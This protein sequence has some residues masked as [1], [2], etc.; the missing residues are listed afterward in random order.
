MRGRLGLDL[1]DLD[2]GSTFDDLD[3]DIATLLR[4]GD[5]D[6][7]AGRDS[8]LGLQDRRKDLAAVEADGDDTNGVGN[9]LDGGDGGV[10]RLLNVGSLVLLDERGLEGSTAGLQLRWVDG[11]GAGGGRL[12]D[13]RRGEDTGEVVGDAGRV[14]GATAHDDL[15]NVEHVEAG[16][17]DGTLDQAVE[18]LKDLARNHLVADAVNGGRVVEAF[19]KTLDG[20]LGIGAETESLLG[21]LGLEAELGEGA[22]ILAGVGGVLLHELLGE[23][24]H[25]SVVQVDTGKV[26]VVDSGENGVHSTA[27]GNDGDIGA[28]ATQVSDNNELVSDDGLLAGIVGE[29]GGNGVRDELEDF[30]ASSA[31]GGSEGLTLLVSEVGRHGDDGRG[32]LLA[33]VV[34]GRGGEAAEEAS[35]R[36]GDGDGRGLNLGRGGGCR[37]TRARLSLG[38]GVLLLVLDGE[39]DLAINILGVGGSMAVRGVDRLEAILIFGLA[40]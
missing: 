27:R 32:D 24:V 31:G 22:R 3:Q 6:G 12:D 33:E 14:R 15:V 25:E 23:V 10:R 40:G 9:V 38:G 37:G 8:R 2:V 36:L 34:G 16:L 4:G 18:A 11:S 17:L 29:N 26:V 28:S 30:K 13:G 20:E 21:G 7:T 35:G 19:G 39:G 1:G 5:V